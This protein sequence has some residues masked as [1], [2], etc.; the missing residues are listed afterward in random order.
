MADDSFKFEITKSLGAISQNSMW[1]TELNL[2]S[3]NDRPQ[4]YDIRGW[5]PDHTRMK[6]GITLTA[7]ELLAL[8]ELLNKI[9]I[10]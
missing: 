2:V 9:T 5:S 3:W 1:I 10:E 4:K 7:D 6:K 8:K